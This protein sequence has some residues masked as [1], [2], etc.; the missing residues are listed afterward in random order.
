MILTS[1]DIH[2][3]LSPD[4]GLGTEKFIRNTLSEYLLL[5]PAQIR[6]ARTA[7]GKP[8][9]KDRRLRG[10]QFN[11]SDSH[12]AIV[13]AVSYGEALGVD[14][15]Y[16][17]RKNKFLDIAE[18]Y[19]HPQE[20]QQLRDLTN[21]MERR[22]L[23]FRLWTTKEAYIKAKGLTIGSASLDKVAF[24]CRNQ[25]IEPLFNTP[26]TLRW[27][28]NTLPWRDYLITTALAHKAWQAV[29]PQITVIEID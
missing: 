9:L 7:H 21:D 22:A 1:N 28:F 26:S 19:F 10:L 14:I 20:L 6:L 2:L 24:H 15:E 23:F 12:G 16:P 27:H 5:P 29:K 13:C 17:A 25:H 4:K 18:R 8:Y 11:L 3:W